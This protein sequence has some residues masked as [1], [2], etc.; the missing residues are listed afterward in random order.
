MDIDDRLYEFNTW[1]K[2]GGEITTNWAL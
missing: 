1:K 2:V